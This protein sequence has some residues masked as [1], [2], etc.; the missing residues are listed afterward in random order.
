MS[1]IGSERI[2]Y[3]AELFLLGAEGPFNARQRKDIA[4]IAVL[5]CTNW[6]RWLIPYA[7]VGFIEFRRIVSEGET[8]SNGN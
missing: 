6:N 4:D 2:E 7:E 3:G 5:I 8:V 1:K